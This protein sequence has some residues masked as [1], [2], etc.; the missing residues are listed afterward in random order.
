MTDTP[1][2]TD[3]YDVIGTDL[4]SR[5]SN[6]SIRLGTGQH[7]ERGSRVRQLGS[8]RKLWLLLLS[9]RSRD[10]REQE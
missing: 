2:Y 6:P 9:S 8:M 10:K 1:G 4:S 5:V 7:C 3:Y